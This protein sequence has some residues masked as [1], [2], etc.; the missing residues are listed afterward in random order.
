ML[1]KE[2]KARISETIRQAEDKT[3]GEIRVYVAKHCKGDPLET[4]HKVFHKL[5][6]DKTKLRNGVLIYVSPS[7]HKTAIYA[8]SGIN[9]AAENPA[10]WQDA[11]NEMLIFFKKDLIADGICAGIEKVKKLIKKGYPVSD[12]DLNELDNEVIME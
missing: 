11:L 9:E 10:F 12:N 2:E 8:D 4:A 6:M 1:N 7:D 3:S 5:R